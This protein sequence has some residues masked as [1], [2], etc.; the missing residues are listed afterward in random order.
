MH[1][2]VSTCFN[3]ILVVRRT[4]SISVRRAF[5]DFKSQFR[6]KNAP[7]ETVFEVTGVIL[8][9]KCL[10]MSFSRKS[11][12]PNL[13]GASMAAKIGESNREEEEEDMPLVEDSDE[14]LDEPKAL[15]SMFASGAAFKSASALES[16][17]KEVESVEMDAEKSTEVYVASNKNDVLDNNDT[18]DDDEIEDDVETQTQ[19][20]VSDGDDDEDSVNP[21]D[22]KANKVKAKENQVGQPFFHELKAAVHSL[23]ADS[24]DDWVD[25]SALEWQ[26]KVSSSL[27]RGIFTGATKECLKGIVQSMQ[28]EVMQLSQQMSQS[29]QAEKTLEQLTQEIFSDGSDTDSDDNDSIAPSKAK[30]NTYKASNASASADSDSDSDLEVL[31]DEDEGAIK[32]KI[33]AKASQEEMN[34]N[35]IGSYSS[36]EDKADKDDDDDDGAAGESDDSN[37]SDEED[38]FA[39]KQKQKKANKAKVTKKKQINMSPSPS[40]SSSSPS[41]LET[42]AAGAEIGS[43][44]GVTATA[45]AA[46]NGDDLSDSDDDMLV[47]DNDNEEESS[48]KKKNLKKNSK[49]EKDSNKEKEDEE[50]SKKDS[51]VNQE[52]EAIRAIEEGPTEADLNREK[53]IRTDE[54]VL[55]C[56]Y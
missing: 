18:D 1:V 16:S 22:Q 13:Y 11:F 54:Y 30:A 36:D 31:V 50:G 38:P 29:S 26:E 44:A 17:N 45:N 43:A 23:K 15:P 39:P 20:M 42:G 37:D 19:Q 52:L 9:A 3:L 6:H 48:S 41:P 2:V 46:V 4:I 28:T 51:G 25:W 5:S 33:K 8:Y 56:L 40:K 49:S 47:G 7:S 35:G 21:F 32:A 10:T 53:L 55:I 34:M 27:N 12:K 14:D 24:D